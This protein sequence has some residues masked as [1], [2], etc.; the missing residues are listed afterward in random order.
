MFIQLVLTNVVLAI[1][2]ALISVHL[3]L[4]IYL[5]YSLTKIVAAAPNTLSLGCFL[6]GCHHLL[7]CL[8]RTCKTLVEQVHDKRSW[9]TPSSSTIKWLIFTHYFFCYFANQ[10]D[11]RTREIV[12]YAMNV[13]ILNNMLKHMNLR[14]MRTTPNYAIIFVD[15]PC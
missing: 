5:S 14:K 7:F 15:T 12:V 10:A 9:A 4:Q 2:C 6:V 3:Q 1:P 11:W 13:Y 8:V